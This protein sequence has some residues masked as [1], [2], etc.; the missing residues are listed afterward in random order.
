M[1]MSG[2]PLGTRDVASPGAVHQIFRWVGDLVGSLRS[3]CGGGGTT[4]LEA[5]EQKSG[6]WRWGRRRQAEEEVTRTQKGV[7]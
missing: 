5:V 7:R 6:T 2:K 3:V 4:G 1:T